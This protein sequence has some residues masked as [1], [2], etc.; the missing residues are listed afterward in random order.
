[1]IQHVVQ[2]GRQSYGGDVA[3]PIGESDHPRAKAQ[4]NDPDVLNAVRQSRFRSCC[5]SA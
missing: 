5:I 1:M 2:T 3:P 4:E